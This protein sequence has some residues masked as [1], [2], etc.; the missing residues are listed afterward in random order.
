MQAQKFNQPFVA[1]IST[2]KA[3]CIILLAS[4]CEIASGY[5]YTSF[6]YANHWLAKL[7]PT[8]YWLN[9]L[10]RLST[11]CFLDFNWLV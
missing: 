1:I 8:N 7:G 9:V 11:V 2:C 4:Y 3:Y 10:S 6:F 5:L